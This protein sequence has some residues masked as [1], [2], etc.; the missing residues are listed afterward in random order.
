MDDD[1]HND[2]L[3]PDK[4]YQAFKWIA[5]VFLPA[6]A[7]FI[8]TIGPVV[9]ILH[10]DAIVTVLNALV[11]LIATCIGVSQVKGSKE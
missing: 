5:L 6:L 2:Y 8:N 9:G 7:I 10:V 4:V 11:L 1:K 3:L